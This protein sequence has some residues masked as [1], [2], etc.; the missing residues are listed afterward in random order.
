MSSDQRQQPR[1]RDIWGLRLLGAFALSRD[2]AEVGLPAGTQRLIALAAVLGRPLCRAE[3]AATLWPDAE[4]RRA[5]GNLR[6]AWWRARRITGADLFQD[7]GTLGLGPQLD[8][9]LWRATTLAGDL[10]D[11]CGR[12]GDLLLKCAELLP[13]WYDDWVLMPRE[14]FI[15][16]RIAALITY[17]GNLLAERRYARSLQAALAAVAADPLRDSAHAAVIR[18]LLARQDVSAAV[19]RYREFRELLRA[20]LAV[21]PSA[22]VRSLMSEVTGSREVAVTAR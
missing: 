5:A 2:G 11:G 1:R 3:A 19:T 15:Q 6:S 16:L 12:D 10:I 9:D 20:E 4:P 18:A 8:V 22:E 17:S 21:E 7:A 14:R 13:G